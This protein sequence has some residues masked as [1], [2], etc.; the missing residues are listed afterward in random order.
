MA[1]NEVYLQRQQE[2]A[3]I[4]DPEAFSDEVAE[5]ERDSGRSGN[6]PYRRDRAYERARMILIHLDLEPK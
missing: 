6:W 4:I 2:L 1:A 5:W 3:L